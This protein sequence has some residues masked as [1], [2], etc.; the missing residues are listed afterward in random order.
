M[1]PRRSWQRLVHSSCELLRWIGAV[2]LWT[3][4]VPAQTTWVV[5]LQNRPGAQFTDLSAAMLAAGDGDVLLLRAVG[6]GLYS[7]ASIQN[8]GLVIVGET[9][10]D[11]PPPMIFGILG[12]DRVP[13]GSSF[14]LRNVS[15]AGFAYFGN[16]A[17]PVVLDGVKALPSIFNATDCP[18]VVFRSC[19]V[20][21]GTGGP[22]SSSSLWFLRCGIHVDS[23]SI[24]QA[25]A[26]F[27]TT[28][29]FLRGPIHAIDSQLHIANSQVVG[30]Y[31][32]GSPISAGL[33][34]TVYTASAI[35]LWGSEA[36]LT[37]GSTLSGGFVT[38]S[39]SSSTWI[40]PA[41]GGYGTVHRD[42][43]VVLTGAAIAPSLTPSVGQIDGLV[44]R[45]ALGRATVEHTSRAGAFSVLM[46]APL[47]AVPWNLPIG[48]VLLD[49]NVYWTDWALVPASARVT[50][51]LDI[52]PSLPLGTWVG[53]QAVSLHPP[54][55]AQVSNVSIAGPF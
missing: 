35:E 7:P 33:P 22:F 20:L 47:Q 12:V 40:S 3:A 25:Y 18:L 16:C 13:A 46:V 17:G 29:T 38:P 30:S 39:W 11:L 45:S 24:D 44:S 10:R 6:S 34:P 52:P 27:G 9:V 1:K 50:R 43:S 32:F 36:R 41:I 53:L 4:L 28:Q 31:T 55:S 23:C 37:A 19:R 49:P 42:P 2:V 54:G 26:G 8:K 21:V 48:P 5:D 14:V 51:K 15:M